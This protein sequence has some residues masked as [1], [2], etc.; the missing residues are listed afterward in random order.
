MKKH[1]IGTVTFPTVATQIAQIN[2]L[3]S[4]NQETKEEIFA[5][6]R[7]HLPNEMGKKITHEIL[8]GGLPQCS[9]M[10]YD[11]DH[12]CIL[13]RDDIYYADKSRENKGIVKGKMACNENG[14]YFF[15]KSI[16]LTNLNYDGK[17]DIAAVKKDLQKEL[18]AAFHYGQAP[19]NKLIIRKSEKYTKIYVLLKESGFNLE[20]LIQETLAPDFSIQL[21]NLQLA[22][23][24]I[25][26]IQ[27]TLEVYKKGDVHR[28]IKLGN[29][30]V[31]LLSNEQLQVNI[32]DFE[33]LEK[34]S[35]LA[36]NG[37]SYHLSLEAPPT[38]EE[39]LIPVYTKRLSSYYE[40][41]ATDIYAILLAVKKIYE[42]ITLDQMSE[43]A[44]QVYKKLSKLM[45]DTIEIIE[46][47]CNEKP[48]LGHP[49]LQDENI[50]QLEQ[51]LPDLYEELSLVSTID[52]LLEEMED[53]SLKRHFPEEARA[54][55]EDAKN[56]FS[57]ASNRYTLLMLKIELKEIQRKLSKPQ[58]FSDL[59]P[60]IEQELNKPSNVTLNDA[61]KYVQEAYKILGAQRLLVS[62]KEFNIW[63]QQVEETCNIFGPEFRPTELAK[64]AAGI[65]HIY[66]TFFHSEKKFHGNIFSAVPKF[67]TYHALKT[68]FQRRENYTSA[69]KLCVRFSQNRHTFKD[70]EESSRYKSKWIEVAAE[71][72]AT[73]MLESSFQ[74]LDRIFN[75]S[76]I[77]R[78]VLSPYK[79]NEVLNSFLK[80]STQEGQQF[81]GT[82]LALEAISKKFVTFC[83]QQ[84]IQDSTFFD[85]LF[86]KL[87]THFNQDENAYTE[88]LYDSLQSKAKR[89]DI[90][91][92]SN[93]SRAGCEENI[94]LI[95]STAAFF[96]WFINQKEASVR[97]TFLT[98]C[99]VMHFNQVVLLEK[100]NP[101][102]SA[103]RLDP[104]PLAP[105]AEKILQDY[106]N[107][108]HALLDREA[109]DQANDAFESM[110]WGAYINIFNHA[111][112]DL[113]AHDACSKPIDQIQNKD[114]LK[115]IATIRETFPSFKDNRYFVSPL[116]IK[117][118]MGMLSGG[119]AYS[120]IESDR[121]PSQ[122][123]NLVH[124][125]IIEIN[126]SNRVSGKN[127][128]LDVIET[129]HKE[130][131]QSKN[132]L[133][134]YSRFLINKPK[135]QA[136]EIKFL[137]NNLYKINQLPIDLKEKNKLCNHVVAAWS[138][139]LEWF[140]QEF[141]EIS[142]TKNCLF[143]QKS[144]VTD[145]YKKLYEKIHLFYISISG[146]SENFNEQYLPQYP[147]DPAF[148]TQFMSPYFVFPASKTPGAPKK[149]QLL[150][151]ALRMLVRKIEAQVDN[152]KPYYPATDE[153][154][155]RIIELLD[156]K[157]FSAEIAP[158]IL[159]YS[160]QSLSPGFALD[161]LVCCTAYFDENTLPQ[162]RI[163]YARA[164]AIGIS[165]F[166]E[167]AIRVA[168]DTHNDDIALK[169]FSHIAHD[170]FHLALL[171]DKL[172]VY[173]AVCAALY[174]TT[175]SIYSDE[176][177]A[178]ALEAKV[179][180][181]S[182]VHC[183][184][185]PSLTLAHHSALK[186][187]DR[188]LIYH[189]PLQILTL[190][191]TE[192]HIHNS[193]RR[194]QV[195]KTIDYIFEKKI[196]CS[197]QFEKNYISSSGGKPIFKEFN[198]RRFH[199]KAMCAELLKDMLQRKKSVPLSIKECVLIILILK[200]YLQ[201][202]VRRWP[203]RTGTYHLFQDVFVY[204][205]VTNPVNLKLFPESKKIDKDIAKHQKPY[206]KQ[207][208]ELVLPY[209][210]AEP[211]KFTFDYDEYDYDDYILHKEIEAFIENDLD[212]LKSIFGMQTPTAT[213]P[214]H[215]SVFPPAPPQTQIN[216]ARPKH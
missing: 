205:T 123:P 164:I 206:C 145:L 199:L 16:T 82:L 79:L 208:F 70:Y 216:G 157:S 159:E 52:H 160:Q 112:L 178:K 60:R 156:Q 10:Y 17:T 202:L 80:I 75:L 96:Q 93:I 126:G 177:E 184:T 195:I 109:M 171:N 43:H 103:H 215:L 193:F 15:L 203:P 214:S 56:A 197:F 55:E 192:E 69:R 67:Y 118:I 101:M 68:Y 212:E 120:A 92:T 200:N 147:D 12:L 153:E 31:Q 141:K 76:L 181:T 132:L 49:K 64:A 102:L 84:F 175:C 185:F 107:Q 187:L 116:K 121:F 201:S 57:L 35:H 108:P 5:F 114:A 146:E 20:S 2:A 119:D 173:A 174:L 172:N 140:Q 155:T 137:L 45:A 131:L 4:I 105:T 23:I 180:L 18:D 46:G 161:L 189:S 98:R 87:L 61:L 154:L 149:A 54:Q 50:N 204:L 74:T 65:V 198:L 110:A 122:F 170:P 191:N 113:E 139:Q 150:Y 183:H 91:P 9:V 42:R 39:L 143:N 151:V 40:G 182:L 22:D 169:K 6:A 179:A 176:N 62:Q 117:K 26:S 41:G 38:R 100:L 124:N 77:D 95:F 30:L 134:F 127:N 37:Q 59:L 97:K 71:E 210:T 125:I 90:P 14:E 88:F 165:S 152:K 19:H 34:R 158:V 190:R 194:N 94:K 81:N 135:I 11:A 115:A 213:I 28:D 85:T 99:F 48:L 142:S 162:R 138:Q 32:T 3:R 44:K 207:L 163:Q 29:F 73:L 7:Q 106:I 83:H 104:T 53:Q 196:P 211:N 167:Y 72:I 33:Y 86:K 128:H 144:M 24:I 89:N 51:A 27:R 47:S 166:C 168:H 111:N 8:G 133:I 36:E 188:T 63:H 129:M 58:F 130:I 1:L 78:L 136:Q 21:S 13:A 25:Q 186:K 209:L 66:R 148:E